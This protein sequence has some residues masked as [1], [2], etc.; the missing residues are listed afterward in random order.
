MTAELETSLRLTFWSEVIIRTIKEKI[1]FLLHKTRWKTHP[2]VIL[3]EITAVH[4]DQKQKL[5]LRGLS[6]RA[7]YTD[8][9]TG[10]CHRR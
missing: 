6:P 2:I 7:N 1:Q 3:R 9:A 10:A 8:R 5:K 4:A